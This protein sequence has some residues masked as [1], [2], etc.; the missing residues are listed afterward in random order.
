MDIFLIPLLL[1]IKSIISISIMIII[2]DVVISWLIVANILNTQNAFVLS[3]TFALS[4]FSNLLLTPIKKIFP[5][6]TLGSIDMSP[7]ILILTLTFIENVV[8]RIL[9]KIQ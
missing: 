2:I 3:V 8:N 5:M 9:I 6:T 7:L 4:K 1:C